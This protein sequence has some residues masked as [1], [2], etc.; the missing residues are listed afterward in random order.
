MLHKLWCSQEHKIP[1]DQETNKKK[2][3]KIQD[4]TETAQ[5]RNK[6]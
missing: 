2:K 4:Q 3:R 5:T 6:I 1:D